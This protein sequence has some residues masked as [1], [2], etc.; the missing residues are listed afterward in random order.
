MAGSNKKPRAAATA[1]AL[2][3]LAALGLAIGIGVIGFFLGRDTAPKKSSG[4]AAP[5]VTAPATTAATTTTAAATTSAAE[6]G[7]ALFVSSCGSCHTLKDAGT[8]GAVGPNLDDLKP[9]LARVAKQVT[10]GGKIMP[11]FKGSLTPAQI[12][13]VAAYVSSVAGQ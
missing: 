2:F 1:E 13:Q 8:S 9:S 3:I 6:A 4:T 11:S 12:Q 10:N 7:K 5:T